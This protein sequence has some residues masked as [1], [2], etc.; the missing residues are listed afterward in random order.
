MTTGISSM[1]TQH[2]TVLRHE[3]VEALVTSAEGVFVDCTY[4][5]GGHSAEILNKLNS[6][7]RLLVIDKDLVAIE[8]ARNHLGSDDRVL[9]RQGS[10]CDLASFLCDEGIAKVDGVLMDLGVSSPQLDET[11]RGFSFSRNGPLD[12]RMN[13][14][15]GQT[16][17]EWLMTAD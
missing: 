7:G 3:A 15:D 9:I 2:E 12:M 4:G 5:R 13:Q 1:S 8:H 14:Q 10:F 17:S 6:S 11:A 16:A